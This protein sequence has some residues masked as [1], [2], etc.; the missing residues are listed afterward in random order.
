MQFFIPIVAITMKEKLDFGVINNVI[1]MLLIWSTFC[2]T[3]GSEQVRVLFDLL[4]R[5]FLPQIWLS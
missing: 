1:L 4:R 2:D 5:I 3:F